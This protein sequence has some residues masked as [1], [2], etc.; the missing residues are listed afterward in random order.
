MKTRP[1]T[2]SRSATTCATST[3]SSARPASTAAV[4]TAGCR[5]NQ[6]ESDALRAQLRRQG[7]AVVEEPAQADTVYV[8][9]CTVTAAADRSSLQLVHRAARSGARVVVLGCLA[10]REPGR[11]TGL[12][13]VA[14]VWDNARKQAE[15]AGAVPE[16]ARSRALLKVQDGCARRC[17]YCVVSGLR[18]P[19]RSV[20]V[21]AVERAL[22]ELVEQ[23]F[24]EIVLTGLNLGAYHE[25][26][27][28]T[29]AGLL[30]RLLGR[31][32]RFRVRL[33]SVEPDTVDQRL[34]R[35]L[36]HEKLC[37]HLHLPMQ[38]GDDR[39]LESTGRP[40]RAAD[41]ARLCD[42]AVRSNP[43]TAIGAD[44]ICGLPGEDEESFEVTRR[45]IAGLPVAYLHAFTFSPRPGTRAEGMA[46]RAET[47]SARARVKELRRFSDERRAGFGARYIGSERF[48]L[49]ETDRTA[50]TDNYLKLVLS[51]CRVEP[52]RLCRVRIGGGDGGLTGIVVD[53]PAA[54]A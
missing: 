53:N 21:A 40:Y 25:A 47:H 38:T 33:G 31:P 13:G 32:G 54:R 36:S 8:N 42:A 10:E 46:G 15:L 18:G 23:G 30:E 1:P 4:L 51:G 50:L 17:A 2:S 22:A 49:A 52:G 16:P 28:T 6:S 11:V 27:G 37:P 12:A 3:R 19:E 29:L 24:E 14:E 39:L 35:L 7:I 48:A 26:N 41:F 9:T 45:F 5:L 43:D 44:V 20:P 34:L